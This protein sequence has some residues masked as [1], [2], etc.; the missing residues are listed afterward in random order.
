M[1]EYAEEVFDDYGW[2]IAGC[3]TINEFDEAYTE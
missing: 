2:A 3:F 1:I